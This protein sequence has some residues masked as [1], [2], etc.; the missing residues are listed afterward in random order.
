MSDDGVVRQSDAELRQELQRH[1]GQLRR[2]RDDGTIDDPAFA[3]LPRLRARSPVLVFAAG[4]QTG[5][6]QCR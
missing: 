5:E 1:L 3:A 2:L 6:P 4:N